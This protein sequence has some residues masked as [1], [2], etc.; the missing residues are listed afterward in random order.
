MLILLSLTLLILLVFYISIK[1]GYII[2]VHIL[3][4]K[5]FDEMSNTISP[6]NDLIL[7]KLVMVFFQ[8]YQV[9]MKMIMVS[10]NVINS[11]F[12]FSP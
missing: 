4:N 3:Y 7:E 8:N 9:K 12:I 6:Q 2:Y 10:Y 1:S 11:E 5:F